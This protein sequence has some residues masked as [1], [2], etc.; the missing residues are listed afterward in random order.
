MSLTSNMT[1]Q[2]DVKAS[3]VDRVGGHHPFSH[4]THFYE[5]FHILYNIALQNSPREIIFQ[6]IRANAVW[7]PSDVL[8]SCCDVMLDV[9]AISRSICDKTMISG[10]VF[11]VFWIW[12][13]NC[14][15]PNAVGLTHDALT[16]RYDVTF[17]VKNDVTAW[18][19]TVRGNLRACGLLSLES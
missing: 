8:T 15:T 1:S 18:R 13:F 3:W 17:D 16:S 12:N 14:S 9:N 11:R 6:H 4:S 10:V 7:L 19:P 2:H 5:H